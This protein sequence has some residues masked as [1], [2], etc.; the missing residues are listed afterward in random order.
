MMYFTFKANLNLYQ[1]RNFGIKKSSDEVN[2][3]VPRKKNNFWVVGRN[4]V[5]LFVK[6]SGIFRR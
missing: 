1:C 6:K 5:I 3:S 2:P 4:A